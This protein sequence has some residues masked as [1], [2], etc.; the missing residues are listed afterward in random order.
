MAH[1]SADGQTVLLVVVEMQVLRFGFGEPE[2]EEVGCARTGGGPLSPADLGVAGASQ[3]TSDLVLH[4]LGHSRLLRVCTARERD[5]SLVVE[6][7]RRLDFRRAHES[8][9][10]RDVQSVLSMSNKTVRLPS[11]GAEGGGRSV[12]SG[13]VHSAAGG[14]TS[15]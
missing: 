3:R 6:R 15:S 5:V 14:S 13:K 1:E 4:Q 8:S 7:R 2:R 12:P 10:E 9:S 11:C